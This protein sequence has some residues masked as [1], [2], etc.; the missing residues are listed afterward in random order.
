[1]WKQITEEQFHDLL[2]VG[3]ICRYWYKPTCGNEIPDFSFLDGCPPSIEW[4]LA[5][6]QRDTANN[7]TSPFTF[8]TKTED[9][10]EEA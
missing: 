6:F 4:E 5:E 1:M 7:G 10:C 3:V 2:S 8:W 9:C